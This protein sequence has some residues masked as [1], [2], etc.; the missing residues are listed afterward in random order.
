MGFSKRERIFV[1]SALAFS[2]LGWLFLCR[3]QWQQASR[4]K[5]ELG[6]MSQSMQGA[7]GAVETSGRL[8]AELEAAHRKLR[9]L[10]EKILSRRNLTRILAQLAKPAGQHRI[11]IVSMKPTEMKNRNP[12]SLY[13]TLPIE[14][15]IRCRYL[16]LGRYLED[17][18][19]GPFLLN[20]KSFEMK[21]AEKDVPTLSVHLILNSYIWSGR[22]EGKAL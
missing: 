15:E 14:V 16:D 13:E 20:V 22:D 12:D 7:R 9:Y 5:A 1:I 11:Q 8:K 6:Q 10:D 19:A 4:L 21:P 2:L 17:L 18:Q 3:P